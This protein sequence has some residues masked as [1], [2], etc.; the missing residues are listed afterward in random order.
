LTKKLIII[1]AHQD[2]EF[3]IFNRISH[4][5]N[6]KDIFIFYMTSG[7]N[8]NLQKNKKNYRDIESIN[9]LKKFGINEKNIF[10]IGRKLS[11]NSNKLYRSMEL[12][13]K[14][15]FLNIN[16][17]NGKKIIFTHALE[18]GHEDHDACNYL[19]KVVYLKLKSV[20]TAY[21]FPAYHGKN[22][23][24]IFYKVFSP[25][26]EN[27][28]ILKKNFRFL[29][30]FKFI[31]FLFFYKSQLK[32]WLGLYPFIII[33][34]LFAKTDM[35]QKLEKKITVRRPHKGMLLYEKRGFCQYSK[36][37]RNILSFLSNVI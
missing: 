2:D 33:K 37:R 20:C 15:L 11:I 21:Q 24:Y 14:E 8:K 10:F 36:F 6:K 13:F 12:A 1:L 3:C 17:I 35:L 7:M 23:P 18:G 25:I 19:A 28:K 27:G 34:F 5:K 30:R 9:V 32:V 4:H 26:N 31:Y 29:D 22:L 16:K